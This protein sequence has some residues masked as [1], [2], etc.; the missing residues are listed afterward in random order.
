MKKLIL[1][2]VVCLAV[3]TQGCVSTGGGSGSASAVIEKQITV[4]N[5]LKKALYSRA[6]FWVMDNFTHPK[7][8]VKFT[9]KSRGTILGQY[10]LAEKGSQTV[11]V[12]I[13]IQVVNNSAKMTIKPAPGGLAMS[14]YSERDAKDDVD[15]L[16]ASFE[17]AMRTIG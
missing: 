17:K 1:M 16:F 15:A 6:N 10:V 2:A 5:T 12:T 11:S 4:E 8:V 7:S 14:G 3:F 13:K 9:D